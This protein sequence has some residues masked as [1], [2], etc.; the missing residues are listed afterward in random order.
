MNFFRHFPVILI[1]CALVA[2]GGGKS[3]PAVNPSVNAPGAKVS[4]KAPE[5]TPAPEPPPS[6]EQKMYMDNAVDRYSYALGVDFGRAV[7]NINVPVKLDVLI[8]AMR[9][10][11]DSSREVLMTDSQSEAAL[12]DLLAQMQLQKEVD[13]AT[14]ARKAL[15]D[16]AAFLAKNIRDPK[17]KVTTK[18]VQ[19]IVLKE[20]SGVKPKAADKVQ[21]HYVG[22]LLDGTEFD[23]SVKRGA[24]MEFAVTAVIE[25]WQDLL[26]AMNV[27]E[28]VRA[29]IPSA[30]AYGE[31]G[32]PPSIP[33]NSLL[34]FE[35]EL[36][37]VFS[38]N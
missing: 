24:P 20:G 4:P 33:P 6:Q 10:V 14:A 21:V 29:W 19:Y 18:G 31:A 30:L 17:V 15:G 13:D 2:C 16:Q 23:N 11:I 26:L 38:A 37:Q 35:V 5:L 7:S 12:Q 34:I 8:D 28:K 36:L 9:D 32:A 25:G 1:G 22:T 27:G 3:T